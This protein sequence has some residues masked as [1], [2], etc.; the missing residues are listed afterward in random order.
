MIQRARRL[1]VDMYRAFFYKIPLGNLAER[2][3]VMRRVELYNEGYRDGF[4][5]AQAHYDRSSE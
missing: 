3:V 1:Y 5:A 2:V 4:K